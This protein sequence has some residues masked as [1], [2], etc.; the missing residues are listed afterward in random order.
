MNGINY[1]ITA[2][3]LHDTG[4]EKSYSTSNDVSMQGYGYGVSQ[5]PQLYRQKLDNDQVLPRPYLWSF[6]GV[7]G[8]KVVNKNEC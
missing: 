7:H 1:K 6:E 4:G 5:Y 2:R 8:D 3:K